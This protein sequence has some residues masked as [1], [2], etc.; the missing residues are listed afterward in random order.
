MRRRIALIG[1]LALMMLLP[2]RPVDAV[3]TIEVEAELGGRDV[4]TADSTDPIRIEPR[5]EVPL[6]LTLRNLGDEVEE[7][8]Y[9]RLEGKALGLTFLTYDLG[10]RTTLDPGERATVATALDFFDLDNQATGYLGTSLRVYDPNRQLLGEQRFV[11]DVRGRA[12]STLG[13]FAI[14]VVGISIFSV[15]VLVL[16]TLRRRLP[17][18]R[19]VRGLQFAVAGSAVGVTLALGVA[20]LR[21]A[22]ADVEAWVPLVTLPT[23]IAFAVGYIAPGPLSRSIRDVREEALREVADKVAARAARVSSGAF[24]PGSGFAEREPVSVPAEREDESAP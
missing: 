12:T 1:L 24:I 16:N 21:V 19:F 13:L 5:K 8:R 14:V 10:V 23:V 22:F 6:E 3:S 4:T 15:T 20:I 2:S 17:P 11:V 9:V 7:I 18:N